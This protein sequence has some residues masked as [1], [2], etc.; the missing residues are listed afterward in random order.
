MTMFPKIDGIY[1]LLDDCPIR[2][3]VHEF[4]ENLYVNT[5]PLIRLLTPQD[6]GAFHDDDG[7][8]WTIVGPLLRPQPAS[9]AL[10]EAEHADLPQSPW[11]ASDWAIEQIERLT[12][13]LEPFA[14]A[15]DRYDSLVL[16]EDIDHWSCKDGDVTL[17]DLRKASAVLKAKSPSSDRAA[18]EGWQPIETAPKDKTPVIVAVLD[19]DCDGFSVG[20]AYFD[21]EHY[22]D[23]DWWWAGTRADDWGAGPISD[24]NYHN[25]S[26]WRPLPAPP[27]LGGASH[28]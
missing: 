4:R 3:A 25:P 8:R 2:C 27:A 18:S 12:K 28:E 24:V 15:A 23:G 1:A 26:L 5:G 9:T 7:R 22:E 14:A 19:K 17:G 20:E 16:G 11:P 13:A 21:P 10:V 6:D